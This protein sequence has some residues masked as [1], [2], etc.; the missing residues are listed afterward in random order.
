MNG[1]NS[2]C[3]TGAHARY[4]PTIHQRISITVTVSRLCCDSC[5]PNFPYNS[6]NYSIYALLLIKAHKNM[7][8]EYNLFYTNWRIFVFLEPSVIS[9][10]IFNFSYTWANTKKIIIHSFYISNKKQ[11]NIFKTLTD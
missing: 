11:M 3:L 2:V 9:L 5:I 10:Q 7:F 1:K 4:L 8:Y 6:R